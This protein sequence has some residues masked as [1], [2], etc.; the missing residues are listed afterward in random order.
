MTQ[1]LFLRSM[2]VT[3]PVTWPDFAAS[4]IGTPPRTLSRPP[5]TAGE[6]QAIESKT[7]AVNRRTVRY[8]VRSILASPFWLLGLRSTRFTCR[9]AGWVGV[10]R[11]GG[12]LPPRRSRLY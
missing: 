4:L 7:K 3:A 9:A 8:A 12:S 6:V 11:R 1:V 2:L 10:R 5:A